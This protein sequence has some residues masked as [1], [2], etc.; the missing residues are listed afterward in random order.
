MEA[1]RKSE[2]GKL[3]HMDSSLVW[4]HVYAGQLY[5]AEESEVYAYFNDTFVA[6]ESFAAWRYGSSIVSMLILT[7][8]EDAKMKFNRAA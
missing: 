1:R 3:P 4:D 5:G 6:N 7:V 2:T 8:K